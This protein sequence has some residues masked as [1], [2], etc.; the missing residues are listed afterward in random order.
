MFLALYMCSSVLVICGRVGN[1]PCSRW[2]LAV[3]MVEAWSFFGSSTGLEVWPQLQSRR[4]PG[5]CTR[6]L[7]LAAT[8]LWPGAPCTSNVTPPSRW[9]QL[10]PLPSIFHRHLRSELR[11]LHINS[12]LP[13]DS[14]E[15]LLSLQQPQKWLLPK[16]ITYS[17]TPSPITRSRPT[18]QLWPLLVTRPLSCTARL[19]MLSSWQTC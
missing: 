11:K 16:F 12:F 9:L 18:M 4:W 1:V 13:G 10:R 14:R 3:C 17:T 6:Y 5:P 19:E 15:L 2:L 8:R 7:A